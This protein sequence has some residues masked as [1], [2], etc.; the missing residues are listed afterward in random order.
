MC[1]KML[2]TLSVLKNTV[3]ILLSFFESLFHKSYMFLSWI[4]TSFFWT[5]YMGNCQIKLQIGVPKFSIL[6]LG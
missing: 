4:D 5:Y 6:K 1:V 3:Q 2:T